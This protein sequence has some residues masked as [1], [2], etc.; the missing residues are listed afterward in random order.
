ML[1]SCP[2]HLVILIMRKYL[3]V[4]A[5]WLALVP[6]GH[7]QLIWHVR[8][9][10]GSY[11]TDSSC[12]GED[13]TVAGLEH[14]DTI[15]FYRLVFDRSTDGGRT[16]REQVPPVLGQFCTNCTYITKIQQVD[17]LHVIALADSTWEVHSTNGG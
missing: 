12:K 6:A 1:R 17:S 14:I 3:F 13:C 10:T 16:W 9:A 4:F 7:A 11:L 2:L 5:A 8:P 15:P